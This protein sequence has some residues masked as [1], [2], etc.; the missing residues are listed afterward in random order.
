MF[1]VSNLITP[2]LAV[3]EGE[4]PKWP[5]RFFHHAPRFAEHVN[6]GRAGLHDPATA[7]AFVAYLDLWTPSVSAIPACEAFDLMFATRNLGGL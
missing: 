7:V 5:T 6:Y 1:N 4:Q 2:A 3:I